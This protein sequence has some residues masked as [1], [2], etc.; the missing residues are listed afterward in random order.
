MT[1]A[2]FFAC[3]TKGITIVEKIIIYG[4]D[5]GKHGA[6]TVASI[7][8]DENEAELK[9]LKSFLFDFNGGY[10][11]A[12]GLLSSAAFSARKGENRPQIFELGAIE[13][14]FPSPLN[15]RK[16]IA[17]QFAIFGCTY[18][19]LAAIG[20]SKIFQVC[21]KTWVSSVCT[22]NERKMDGKLGRFAAVERLFGAEGLKLC[23]AGKTGKAGKQGKLH[24][25]IADSILIAYYAFRELSLQPQKED[26]KISNILKNKQ[27]NKKQK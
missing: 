17:E 12:I 14:P 25:G 6:V 4:I 10:E 27:I 18:A 5:P 19:A 20:P 16:S 11:S 22:E 23:A 3:H 2:C 13:R 1:F 7:C 8:S 26:A 24:D 21:P 9:L 15:A